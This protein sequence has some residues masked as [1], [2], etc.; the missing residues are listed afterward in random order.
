ML[1]LEQMY[2]QGIPCDDSDRFTDGQ[3]SN[4]AGNGFAAPVVAAIALCMLL[5]FSD[6]LPHSRAIAGIGS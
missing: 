1:G 6:V 2:L 3:L 5:E 4:L